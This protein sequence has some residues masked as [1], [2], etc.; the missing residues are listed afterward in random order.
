VTRFDGEGKRRIQTM[1]RNEDDGGDII[2]RRILIEWAEQKSLIQIAETL[3]V[4][5]EVVRKILKREQKRI[6]E[7]GG[8]IDGEEKNG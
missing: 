2:G 4:K 7:R 6:V 1:I 5:L 3:G 8:E